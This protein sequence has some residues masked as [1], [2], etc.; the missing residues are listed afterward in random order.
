M[1]QT[2]ITQGIFL[3]T[4]ILR[5]RCCRRCTER[6]DGDEYFESASEERW[7]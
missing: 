2:L 6:D 7:V 4:K 5:T 3:L 1:K